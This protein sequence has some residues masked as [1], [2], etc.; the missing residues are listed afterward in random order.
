MTLASRLVVLNAGVI[1]QMGTPMEVYNA[2]RNLF[3]AS[4]LGSPRMNLLAGEITAITKAAIKLR[5]MSGDIVAA[6]VDAGRSKIGDRVTLGV[7]PDALTVGKGA[8]GFAATV[9]VVETLGGGRA[10]YCLMASV[11]QPVCALLPGSLSV[12][13][14][15]TLRLCF[16]A[17]DAYLFDAAGHAFTRLRAEKS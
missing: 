3:V 2:P 16:A 12:K 11:A 17:R 13:H 8:N 6:A 7:R 4:F 9:D 10:V 14:D 5:L 15:D 1:E